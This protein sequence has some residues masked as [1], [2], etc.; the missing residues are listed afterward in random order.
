MVLDFGGNIVD[1]LLMGTR[2]AIFD[3]R[4]PKTELQELGDGQFDF[5]LQGDTEDMVT[6]EG[7]ENMPICVTLNKVI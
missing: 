4:I 6:I 1:A 3:T 5:D 2:A 7:R